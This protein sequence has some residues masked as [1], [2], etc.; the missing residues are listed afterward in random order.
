MKKLLTFIFLSLLLFGC[1]N[2]TINTITI[3]KQESHSTTTIYELDLKND[4]TLDVYDIKESNWRLTDTVVLKAD[5]SKLIIDIIELTNDLNQKEYYIQYYMVDGNGNECP[6]VYR[7][8]YADKDNLTFASQLNDN[9]QFEAGSS[10]HL[11][12]FQWSDERG[13]P[14]NEIDL[15]QPYNGTYAYLFVLH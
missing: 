7:Y 3:N 13:T 6:E 1:Q 12:L 14:A 5:Y 4:V 11:A 2:N 15:S 10:T 9:I 8:L